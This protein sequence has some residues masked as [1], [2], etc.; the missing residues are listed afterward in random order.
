[1]ARADNPKWVEFIEKI[2]NQKNV[3]ISS[4]NIS[5]ERKQFE[6]RTTID[7]KGNL[8]DYQ[9]ILEILWDKSFNNLGWKIIKFESS[10]G[11]GKFRRSPWIITV[12][13]GWISLVGDK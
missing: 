3:I 7:L 5:M 13:W 12:N 2:T 4:G 8:G 11:D 10:W 9:K 1:L 6:F